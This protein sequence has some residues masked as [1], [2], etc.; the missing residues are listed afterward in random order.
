[1]L[2]RFKT[3]VLEYFQN[4]EE[5][6]RQLVNRVGQGRLPDDA[7]PYLKAKLYWGRLQS[8]VTRGYDEAKDILADVD[9]LARKT[10][11]DF[12]NLRDA[13]NDYLIA[14]HAPERN[15]VHGDG[16][17]GL[18]DAQARYK[19]GQINARPD[20]ADIRRIAD[21]A[22]ALNNRTLEMLHDADVISTAM[23][24]KLRSI[25]RHHVPL[26]R[27]L[28]EEPNF[29]GA[30][31]GRGFD[32]YTSGIK[33]AKGSDL[34][35]RDILGNVLTNYEQ[36]ALRSE[37][38]LVDLSTLAFVRRHKVDLAGLMRVR[39]PKIIGQRS[40]GSP[41]FEQTADPRILHLFEDGRPV[42]VEIADPH[43]AAA[44]RGIG[45]QQL[46]EFMRFIAGFTRL[47]A[48]LQ[49][50][51][52]PEFA[53]PN[54]LRDLQE[55]LV[56]LAADKNIRG[57]GALKAVTRDPG[58]IKAV[59]DYLA[60]RN[61]PGA[62]RYAE[63]KDVGGTT[64]GL[65]LSTRAQ[66][67]LNVAKLEKIA[68]S[69]PRQ[70]A[71][72]LVELVDH[73]NTIFEDSTRLSIYTTA[74]ERGLSKE[75]AAFH[76][77]TGTVDFNTMGTAGPVI[78]ALWMFSNA[79][80]QGS[81]KMLRSLK[82][83]KVALGLGVTLGSAVAAVIEWN[84]SVDPDW[85][86]KVPKYDRLNS[87]PVMLPT[88]EGEGVRY[89]SLP[90]SWGLKPLYVLASHAYDTAK[91]TGAGLAQMLSDFL[92]SVVEAY[93][94]VGGTDPL[95][96]MA[97]TILDTPIDLGRNQ[98][99]SGARIKPDLDPDLPE[100]ERYFMRLKDTA[101][102][103]A[104]I[105]TTEALHD[106]AGIEV[107]PADLAYATE[108][109]L[110]G[111]GRAAGK[112]F[113]AITGV[114]S[115]TPPPS[116]ELPFIS[117]FYRE[118]A[119][120]ELGQ[121]TVRERD[122][123]QGHRANQARARFEIRDRADDALRR[124]KALPESERPVEF[125]RLKRADREAA[126]IV[127]KQLT[128]QALGQT[129]TDAAILKLGVE[130][131]ERARYIAEQLQAMPTEQRKPYLVQLRRKK[132]LTGPVFRQVRALMAGRQLK[133]R[134]PPVKTPPG[135]GGLQTGDPFADLV[136]QTP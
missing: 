44:F 136:P 25:Y 55:A 96:A 101:S 98:S 57:K 109:Y 9:R 12:D 93:N 94:P 20:A 84:D 19:L 40:D 86:D 107:S 38:N 132:I 108:Q 32:V 78:N 92:V 99:W 103:R 83:P 76:A 18:T 97:P 67:E 105:A 100:D 22:Q 6:I 2:T 68:K 50:R 23:F 71:Q 60:G 129:H 88:T 74:L 24:T 115:G 119:Q 64:G 113:N 66:V 70:F 131:G 65:G 126:E 35:H 7:D 82:N 130:N 124:I 4:S 80:I 45:R 120:E 56:Y 59:L 87:L 127:A 135:Y 1:M 27:V 73:W 21:K 79:S 43:L 37:K 125:L 13:V 33:K 46:P 47:Y 85:R 95:Q 102:G 72:Q 58:S 114:A 10:G 53:A 41:I 52:N 5:R 75:R 16:A 81:A 31:A 11:T 134:P 26:N 110:G 39:P 89:V 69:R 111:A 133:R 49:T 36:A 14:R 30:I 123:I 63:M 15:A 8:K 128:K 62:Q 106:V 17:A 29:A 61:T 121:G 54:K 122:I 118:R 104:A 42:W 91:G 34:E 77:K 112:A 117:R 28:K 3:N 116:A 90:V 48:G 51:F